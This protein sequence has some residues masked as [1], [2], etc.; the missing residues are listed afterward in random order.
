MDLILEVVI[1]ILE[2]LIKETKIIA[3]VILIMVTF[4]PTIN[5]KMYRLIKDS[6]V[7]QTILINLK[8]NNGKSI[9]YSSKNE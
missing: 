2:L 5:K 8:Q 1:M 6:L 3:K 9:N 4:I 7:I